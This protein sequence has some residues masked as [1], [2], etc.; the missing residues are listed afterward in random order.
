MSWVFQISPV[1][2]V[3]PRSDTAVSR[4]WDGH[5]AFGTF[6]AWVMAVG[7]VIVNAPPFERAE[8]RVTGSSSAD[9]GGQV[10]RPWAQGGAFACR[11]ARDGSGSVNMQLEALRK[12]ALALPHTSVSEQWG[13]Q[14]F[15]V[16]G[17]VFLHVVLDAATIE[18]V[19]FKC[20]PEEFDDLVDIDGIA[21]APYFAKHHWVSMSDTLALPATELE[22]RIRRSFDLVVAGLPKKVQAALGGGVAVESGAQAPEKKHVRS[23]R[24]VRGGGS[25]KRSR[26][27]R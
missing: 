16:E 19:I 23:P 27:R 12:F 14:A 17:K 9:Y 6:A 24:G 13:G 8:R 4:Q 22:R 25:G 1:S 18:S 3:V 21:Q 26:K 10:T 5:I 2:C 11:C 7:H 15:K 20:T